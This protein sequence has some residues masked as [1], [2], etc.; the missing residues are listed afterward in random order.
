MRRPGEMPE[1]LLA[2]WRGPAD[3]LP[4]VTGAVPNVLSNRSRIASPGAVTRAIRRKVAL[5]TR[6]WPSTCWDVAHAVV[7]SGPV[8]ANAGQ[9][10]AKARATAISVVRSR[11]KQ[12]RICLLPSMLDLLINVGRLSW[13]GHFLPAACYCNEVRISVTNRYSRSSGAK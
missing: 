6:V 11:D 10:P 5:L 3:T 2:D 12:L 8:C 13:N 9:N 7:Q 4:K 1:G